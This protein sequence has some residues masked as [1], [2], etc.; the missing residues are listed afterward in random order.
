M[1]MEGKAT[2]I[3]VGPGEGTPVGGQ[4]LVIKAFGDHS[5]GSW[6]VLET[7]LPPQTQGPGT[8]VHRSHGEGFYVLEGTLTIALDGEEIE[9]PAGTYAYVPPGIPHS[10]GNRSSEPTR[11]LAICHAGI[12]RML[13]EFGEAMSEGPPDMQRVQ[14]IADRYDSSIG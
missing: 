6:A 8:H 9:A 12:E 7:T 5:S 3:V 1:T 14:E 13:I 11:I 4:G 10:Y 2:A